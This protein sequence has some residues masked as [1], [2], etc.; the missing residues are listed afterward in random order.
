MNSG[1]VEDKM[2]NRAWTV[3][4]FAFFAYCLD[5]MDW[6]F[7]TFAAPAIAQELGFNGTQ[8]GYLLGAPLLGGGIGGI[9]S[10]WFADKVGRKKAMIITLI[11]FSA[12]TILF[13]FGKT[14][15]VLF[16]LRFL[17][18]VGLGAQWGIGMTIMAET[19][20]QKFRIRSSAFIQC[21]TAIGPIVG[22][23]SVQ[24]ILPVFGWRPIF[25]VGSAGFVL[26]LLVW[27][28][29]KESD[30][31]LKARER[32]ELGETKLADVKLLFSRGIVGRLGLCLLMM[33]LMGYA[34]YGSMSWIP[35]WLATTKGM[36]VVK[37]MNYMISL[38][39]GGFVGFMLAGQL[40]DRIGRKP[41]MIASILLSVVAVLVFVSVENPNTLLMIAPLYAFLTY[42]FFGVIGGFFSELFP[43]EVRSTAVNTIF[44]VAR[45]FA[46]FAPSLMAWI[47]T[48]TS[49]TFAI[50][51]TA[52]VY[53]VAVIPLFFLPET[54]NVISLHE[55]NVTSG[56]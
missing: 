38:N 17:A 19:V 10:G 27:M 37:S 23:L 21:A 24:K 51:C 18:G 31:W 34:Y 26:A 53:L 47:G 48:Q 36:G 39:I 5:N 30:V 6:N 49:L 55:V 2:T 9:I 3:V 16:I 54:K 40:A 46:F 14:M 8:M 56:K 7:L 29:M 12:F 44:N 42:P 41:L 32:H 22:A 52:V 25:F 4:I 28:F 20:A 43:T 15:G 45:M 35:T 13:P 1:T 33:L 11:W 50:G